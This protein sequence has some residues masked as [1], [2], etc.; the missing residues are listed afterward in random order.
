LLEETSKLNPKGQDI[1]LPEETDDTETPATT[2]TEQTDWTNDFKIGN[3][4]AGS[5]QPVNPVAATYTSS[6][7]N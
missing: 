7:T 3:E 5:V 4:Q 6:S 2:S 1:T